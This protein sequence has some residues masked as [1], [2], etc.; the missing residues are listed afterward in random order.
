ML[1]IC[2]GITL[3]Y[4]SLVLRIAI[5]W[6]LHLLSLLIVKTGIGVMTLRRRNRSWGVRLRSMIYGLIRPLLH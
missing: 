6:L 1:S 2:S 4:G 5:H 3:V